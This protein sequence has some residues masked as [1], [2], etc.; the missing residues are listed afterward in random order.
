[1]PSTRALAASALAALL[2]VSSPALP[3][4]ADTQAPAGVD[5]DYRPLPGSGGVNL[6][7]MVITPPGEGPHPLLVM[8]AAWSTSN[9]LY[10][11]AAYRLAYESGYQVVSYTS[12]GFWDSGGEVEVAGPEDVADAR[13]VI[14]WALANTDA[15]PERIGM[16]GI[17]YGA[18]ISLLTAAADDR[19][20]AVGAMSGWS[21]LA[22]SI[23][24]NE[25][26]SYQ[27][28]ELLLGSARLTG[29]PGAA[30]RE[31]EEEYRRGN[32]QPALE[33]APERSAATKIEAINANGTAV[34]I[35]HAWNDGIFPP[36]Q[37][38][39]FY[40][41]LTGPKRLMLSPGDHATPEAFGA[42]GLPNETWES[43]TRWFD[44]HLRG[45]D[46]GVDTEAPVRVKPNNGRGDWAAYPDWE[47]VTAEET[48]LHLGRP[49]RT[50]TN[51]QSTGGLETAPEDGWEYTVNA[52]AGTTAESGTL[53]LSGALQQFADIPTGVSLPLVNRRNAGV[54]TGD[55][56]ADGVRVSGSPR[57]HLTVTPTAEEQSLYVYLYAVNSRGT[58]ALIT[59]EPYTLREARPGEPVTVDVEL[60]PVVWDVPAGHRLALVV[61]TRDARYVNETASGDQVVL[62]SPEGDPATL[63]VPTA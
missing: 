48:T 35:G 3:A 6:A 45:V 15:D 62:G 20:R 54:W 55:P 17:S 12:R 41:D 1:M 21:D 49:E 44:H 50:W 52:G 26:I 32:V 60:E 14:D 63:T 56:H 47:S 58:G 25:T 43:L 24:S 38:T 42:F 31:M 19:V 59:H 22:E 61:D 29:R 13:A 40:T 36:G 18:G 10:V 53:F 30:L 51:W 9:L 46:N 37:L 39:D 5:V 8:P 2:L 23:Y 27:A 28:V 4:H 16:A 33:L 57:A 34:M 7:A 11:G